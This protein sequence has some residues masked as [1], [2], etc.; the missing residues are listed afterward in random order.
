MNHWQNTQTVIT[1]FKS[2]DNKRSSSFI[3]LDIMNFYPSITKELLTKSINYSQCIST[4]EEEA[5]TA[6][7]HARKTLL[8]DKTSISFKKDNPDIDVT[9]GSYELKC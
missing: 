2:I 6:I 3:K 1:W 5:I 4:I 9:M 7:F 8:F